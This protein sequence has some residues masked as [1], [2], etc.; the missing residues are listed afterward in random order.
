VA[1]RAFRH[2]ASGSQRKRVR[3]VSRSRAYSAVAIVLVTSR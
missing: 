3:M 2:G 1:L